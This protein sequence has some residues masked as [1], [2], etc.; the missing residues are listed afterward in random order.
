M[1]Y[2][3]ILISILFPLI[4][5]ILKAVPPKWTKDYNSIQIIKKCYTGIKTGVSTQ[6]TNLFFFFKDFIYLFD[7]QRERQPAREGTQAGGVGEEE[8][9]FQAEEGDRCGA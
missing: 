6:G 3:L 2:I 9:G 7:T 1:G 5:S 4:Y 8:A